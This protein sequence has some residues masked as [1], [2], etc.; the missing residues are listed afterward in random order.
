MIAMTECGYKNIPDPTWWTRVLK[1]I[2]DRYPISYFHTWR[3]Y[4]KEF[5]A[6]DPDQYSAEDF[7]KLYRAPNTLFLLDIIE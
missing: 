3:N 6:P 7:K 2:M 1:P 5:F 4:K